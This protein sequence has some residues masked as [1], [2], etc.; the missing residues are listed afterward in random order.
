MS[1]HLSSSSERTPPHHSTFPS[2]SPPPSSSLSPLPDL[3]SIPIA[4]HLRTNSQSDWTLSLCRSNSES[5][6]SPSL[7][8]FPLP[9]TPP[10]HS[11]VK[12]RK[13]YVSAQSKLPSISSIS[14]S[15]SDRRKNPPFPF[16]PTSYSLDLNVG[17][18]R[19]ALVERVVKG[20]ILELDSTGNGND[21]LRMGRGRD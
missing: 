16:L 13:R 18:K 15:S 21:M 7:P 12:E 14:I 9:T 3:L 8:P 17:G 4:S 6:L 20:L 1:T 11:S 2:S 10:K 19:Q 5:S